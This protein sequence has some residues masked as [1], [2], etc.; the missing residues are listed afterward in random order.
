MKFFD[1]VKDYIEACFAISADTGNINLEDFAV[2]I[3][4]IEIAVIEEEIKE[5]KESLESLFSFKVFI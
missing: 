1:F 5:E 2:S 4:D 3:E